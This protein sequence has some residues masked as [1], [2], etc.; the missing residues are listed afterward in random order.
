MVSSARCPSLVM[1][2]LF[3]LFSAVRPLNQRTTLGEGLKPQLSFTE[4]PSFV[5][6]SSKGW[7]T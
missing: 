2:Y 4:L 1:L 3:E 7:D 5:S 6:I